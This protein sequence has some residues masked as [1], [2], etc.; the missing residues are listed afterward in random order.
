MLCLRVLPLLLDLLLN[1][2][3]KKKKSILFS[4]SSSSSSDKHTAVE[5]LSSK[6]AQWPQFFTRPAENHH[7]HLQLQSAPCLP[8]RHL[9]KEHRL[10]RLALSPCSGVAAALSRRKPRQES[11]RQGTRHTDAL[12]WSVCCQ[13]TPK[14]VTRTKS[15][16]PPK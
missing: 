13:M 1:T 3:T 14:P 8:R 7:E 2:H 9:C 15:C 11:A 10:L 6:D 16:V 4:F 5:H 12:Q